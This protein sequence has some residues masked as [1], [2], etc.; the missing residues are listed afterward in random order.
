MQ[1]KLFTTAGL[2]MH[3]HEICCAIVHLLQLL[4]MHAFVCMC[5][6]ACHIL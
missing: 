5:M 6:H 1:L 4:C 2:E 3:K